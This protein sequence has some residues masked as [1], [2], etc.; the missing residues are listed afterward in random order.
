M[1]S[2]YRRLHGLFLTNKRYKPAIRVTKATTTAAT[3]EQHLR[4][5]VEKYKKLSET[6]KFRSHRDRYMNVVRRFASA[7][8]PSLVHEFLEH[9]K[10][11]D[12]ITDEEFTAHFIFLYGR[13][14]MF[15]H[16]RTLFDEMPQLN[17]PRTVRSL[18]SL[19]SA[20]VNSR[21]F[22]KIEEIFREL[23]PKLGIEPDRV[24]YNTLVNAFCE[25]GA[26]DSVLSVVDEMEKK[27][28]Q[29]DVITFNTLLHAFY[30]SGRFADGEKMWDLMESKDI[31]PNVRSYNARM[32]GLVSEDRL[33][34]AI[35]MFDEMKSKGVQPD[36]ITYNAVIRKF[37]Q[38]KN[39]EE[40][41]NWYH[42]L[43]ENDCDPDRVT[44]VTLVPF[45]SENGEFDMA[46]EMCKEILKRGL[47]V[48]PTLFQH[49]VDGL[50]EESRIEDARVLV[51]L[52]R[53]NHHV[54][55]YKLKMPG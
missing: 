34:E 43:R 35:G 52:A 7:N 19:L 30:W 53:S 50:I 15:D 16:A 2:L 41:K 47:N 29:P 51:K 49:V 14:K 17:C 8:M 24:S 37:C 42:K 28:I 18:N 3:N 21:E 10:K 23:A 40:A 54:R 25:M 13:C 26:L 27:G 4:K 31:V 46:L 9:Q 11:V 33:Q 32:R 12:V 22:Q 38:D 5:M 45:L 44:Y 20:C 36:S 1:S 39:L 6:P 48:Q 55:Y